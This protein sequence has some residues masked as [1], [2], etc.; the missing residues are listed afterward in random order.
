MLYYP[1]SAAINA[2]TALGLGLF[3]L[4]QST[5]RQVHRAF[6]YF[7]FSLAAW[8]FA[9]LFWQLSNDAETAL[10]WTR[11]LMVGAIFAPVTYL[12]FTY[13]FLGIYKEN[14]VPLI[15]SYL[16]FTVFLIFDFTPF[17][18]S[19]VEPI[20]GFSFWP[21]PGFVF[22]I[23]LVVWFAYLL[24]T[25]ILLVKHYRVAGGYL[26]SQLNYIFLGIFILFVGGSTNYF[27]W[28]KIPIAPYGNIFVALDLFIFTYAITVYRLM[29]I[30][31]VLRLGAVFSVLFTIVASFYFVATSFLSQV[32]GNTLAVL[33]PA[34]VIV[35]T[36]TPL[37]KLIERVT[38]TIFFQSKYEFHDVITKLTST[39]YKL[40]P[41]LQP[42]LEAFNDV[43]I[44]ALKVKNVG[45]GVVSNHSNFTALR[46]TRDGGPAS[47]Q[48]T[49]ESHLVKYFEQNFATVID[50]EELH[51]K[52]EKHNLSS[53]EKNILPELDA[54]GFNVAI[55]I[56]SKGELMLIYLLGPKKSNDI[57]YR[58]D[59]TLLQN[60]V[61]ELAPLIDN[62][63]L[64]T[65][66]KLASE[67]KTKFINIVSHQLRTPIS[68]VR[69]S[70]EML[71]EVADQVGSSSEKGRLLSSAYQSAI[72]LGEQVD[73]ILIALDIYDKKVL[74]K[75]EAINLANIGQDVFSELQEI[76]KNKK[77]SIDFRLHETSSVVKK[78]DYGK[79]KKVMYILI[80]NAVSYSRPKS[81]V[82]IDARQETVDNKKRIVVSVQDYGIGL[83]LHEKEH[84]FDEFFRGDEARIMMPDGLGLGMFIAQAFVRAH[85]GEFW[86]SSE[87]RNRGVVFYFA[88]PHE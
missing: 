74:L 75:K 66:L 87:G 62:A 17:F 12:H 49:K 28:Y 82:I 39:L 63:R 21:M 13:A 76:I 32:L 53:L 86:F 18:V 24:Y 48:L 61:R 71:K 45:I 52:E 60:A 84:L 2:M 42:I 68:G 83:T 79:I 50:K 10:F 55:P 44:D 70:L 29:D 46:K 31:V 67:A 5:R 43:I 56:R 64:Y 77:L 85:G 41:D 27:Y 37:K 73:D 38:D 1:I 6:V 88:L 25:I 54:I 81:K 16:L 57:F 36:Y 34:L 22:H 7:S 58:D 9:Y 23:F 40:G 8:A 11:V 20:G 80:K 3:I 19:H 30:R 51:A 14:R 78:A 33:I 15:L 59:I 47:L 26:R 65:D 4:A 35:A 69:W 72:F